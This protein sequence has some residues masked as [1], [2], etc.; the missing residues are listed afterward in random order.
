MDS[1]PTCLVR[2]VFSFAQSLLSVLLVL[3]LY[4][5]LDSNVNVSHCTYVH[6][7]PLLHYTVGVEYNSLRA[8]GVSALFGH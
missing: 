3:V 8:V 5:L 6:S 7:I 4:S 2:T 1:V